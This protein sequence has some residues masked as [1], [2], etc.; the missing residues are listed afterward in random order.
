MKYAVAIDIGGT[1]TRVALVND[2]YKI[3]KRIQFS[4]N[5]QDP[6]ETL[7]KIQEEIEKFGKKIEG[8]G[9]SCPGPLDLMSR[10]RTLVTLVVS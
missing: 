6:V 5:P 3:E 10:C 7:H 1:N 2:E 4:T 8:I 9:V